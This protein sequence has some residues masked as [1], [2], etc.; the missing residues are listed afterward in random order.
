ML[1]QFAFGD[2]ASPNPN[3]MTIL[4]AGDLADRAIFF[5]NDR[6]FAENASVTKTRT[7]S[8]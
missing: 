5:R 1:F 4:R 8:C 6:A 2:Q 7:A 3:N